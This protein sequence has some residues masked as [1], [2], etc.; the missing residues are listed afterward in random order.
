M[1]A[2][3]SEDDTFSIDRRDVLKMTGAAVVGAGAFAGSA[4]ASRS[5]FIG[6]TQVCTGT[7]GD[8]AVVWTGEAYECRLLDKSDEEQ[9]SE[10]DDLAFEAQVFACYETEEDEE[11]IVGVLHRDA[12]AGGEDTDVAGFC[13]NP[14]DCAEEYYDSADQVLSELDCDAY[15]EIRPEC[16]G[17]V[18]DEDG[19]EYTEEG[20]T[21][22]SA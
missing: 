13:L 16:I 3:D 9:A 18:Y 2:G 6:C 22:T 14:N 15:D 4:S 19:Q 11:T 21:T 10:R 17:W 8:H 7:D 12:D 20:P 1:T 5:Q